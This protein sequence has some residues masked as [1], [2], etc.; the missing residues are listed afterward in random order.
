MDIGDLI[1]FMIW[2]FIIGGG[3][4]AT[5]AEQL[6]RKRRALA[7][8]IP[9]QETPRQDELVQQEEEKRD[10]SQEVEGDL[11]EELE[12]IFGAPLG[13][14]KAEAAPRPP[15]VK[16]VVIFHPEPAAPP[17]PPEEPLPSP[18]PIIPPYI[19]SERKRGLSELQRAIVFSELLYRPAWYN[20]IRLRRFQH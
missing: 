14:P 6:R 7:R 18:K 8:G 2:V 13:I 10:K 16:E 3:V 9:E 20:I 17:Q 5:L 15:H 1:E 11:L 19:P 4:A 12:E